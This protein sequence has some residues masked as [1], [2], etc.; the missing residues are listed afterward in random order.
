MHSD[1]RSDQL[2]L[3]NSSSPSP[4]VYE[5]WAELKEIHDAIRDMRGPL[6]KAVVEC[7]LQVQ[8]DDLPALNA[9]LQQLDDR[10]ARI[11]ETNKE[12]AFISKIEMERN[13]PDVVPSHEDEVLQWIL[14]RFRW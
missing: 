11:I 6:S 10:L 8:A 2:A 9:L 7:Q 12:A 14:T 4:L 5:G 3:V 13:M 1:H